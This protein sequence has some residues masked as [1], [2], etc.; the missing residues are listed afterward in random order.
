M[1][2]IIISGLSGSGKSTALNVLEDIGFVCIDNLP[3]SLLQ[4]LIT[5]IIV[6]DDR[7]Y[8]IGMDA[9]SSDKDL[10]LLTELVNQE[11]VRSLEP[12]ILFL[13]TDIDELLKRY[14]ETRRK[15]PLSSESVD[16][17]EAIEMER[18]LL[19]PV[20]SLATHIFN[21][22]EM[23]FHDLRALIKKRLAPEKSQS[24]ALLFQSFGFKYG[25]P[26]DADL[27]FDVRCLPN[28]HWIPELRRYTG[29]DQPVIEFLE[30]QAPVKA[31][32]NDL[33]SF[34]DKWLSSFEENN[35]SYMTVAIG[36]T[37]G[38]HRSV[39][40]CNQLTQAL[41]QKRKNVQCRHRE[42]TK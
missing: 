19:N 34:L 10:Q 35:R 12:E 22:T 15:H 18:K 37:G 7:P 8:A 38:Q 3:A 29:N 4:D 31:M 27:V 16:L 28:P 41:S 26:R 11:S 5:R 40:F 17:K 25:V 9:R 21:T 32:Y 33:E 6:D 36:C 39:F 23:K 42:L 24:M 1:R 13:D 14:S 2:L 30:K 20:K